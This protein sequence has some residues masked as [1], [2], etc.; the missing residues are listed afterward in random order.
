MKNALILHATADSLNDNW[1][2]WLKEELIK[3]GYKV[4][5]PNLPDADKPNIEKYNNFIF[6]KWEFNKD[7]ILIGHSSG[8]VAILGILEN[9]PEGVVVERAIL[10][11]GFKDNEDLKWESLDKLFLKPFD[12]EKIRKQCKEFFI[13][14]SDNDPYVT[15]SHAQH[16][17][18]KLKG[19]LII[20]KNQKHF[21]VTTMGEVYRRFPQI[22]EYL[23]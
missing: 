16:L 9:L 5:V 3:K 2:P 17:A 12:W 6:P 13:L 19:K 11:A 18:E 15:L 23:P 7:S 8:A 21:S 22:L 1:Y 4:W 10:V 14:H 20:Y